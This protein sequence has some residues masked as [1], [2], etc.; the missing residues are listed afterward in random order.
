MLVA[1]ETQQ[2]SAAA[3]A[4]VVGV[5]ELAGL[6]WAWAASRHSAEAEALWYS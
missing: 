5:A 3:G 6:V 4:L 1:C 2:R